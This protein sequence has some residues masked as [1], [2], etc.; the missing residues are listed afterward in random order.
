VQHLEKMMTVAAR[1]Y[2]VGPVGSASEAQLT[3]E[4]SRVSG[5]NELSAW[6]RAVEA[7][8][9]V[10]QKL[11]YARGLLRLGECLLNRGDRTAAEPKLRHGL[12][13]AKQLGAFPLI[14]EIVAEGRRANL[15]LEAVRGAKTEGPL[16]A[17]TSR[18]LEVLWLIAMGKSNAAIAEELCISPKTVSVHVSRIF[19][20]LDLRNRTAA[21]RL[22]NKL[23]LD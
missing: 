19:T 7:W 21:A 8:A 15:M 22:A 2:T 16:S 5:A 13:I 1:L 23:G 17:L 20:K 3:A 4:R 10:D 12:G 18:E 14:E 11:E 6:D 9:S